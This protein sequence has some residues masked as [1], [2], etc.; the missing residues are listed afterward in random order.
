MIRFWS[1]G[2]R[3]LTRTPLP[4][5]CFQYLHFF[6]IPILCRPLPTI[7]LREIHKNN[8][9]FNGVFSTRSH[10]LFLA[11]IFRPGSRK[12]SY[13]DGLYH[14]LLLLNCSNLKERGLR[15]NNKTRIQCWV[16]QWIYSTWAGGSF[17]SLVSYAVA[18]KVILMLHTHFLSVL[19]HLY[20]RMPVGSWCTTF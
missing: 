3:G 11:G 8:F 18:S 2:H 20:P 16:P 6:F 7:L 19:I 17:F 5:L 15:Y 4:L 1:F 10:L 13:G 9:S 14:S 12:I